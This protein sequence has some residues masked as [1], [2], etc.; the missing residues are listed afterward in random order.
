MV[1]GEWKGKNAGGCSNNPTH[2]DN[3]QYGLYCEEE[4]RAV[5]SLAQED[6]RTSNSAYFNIGFIVVKAQGML[7]QTYYCP[8]IFQIYLPR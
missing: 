7:L 1:T 2:S 3:P 4:C 5:I 8:H 6:Q